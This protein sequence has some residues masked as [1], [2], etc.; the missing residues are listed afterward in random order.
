MAKFI[1]YS[2]SLLILVTLIVPDIRYRLYYKPNDRLAY[3]C[4]KELE[5][6]LDENANYSGWSTSDAKARVSGFDIDE[7]G[8]GLHKFS[9]Y[10][11]NFTLK[12]A[13]NA[14]V[15]STATCKG[16]VR[17]DKNGDVIV[18]SRRYYQITVL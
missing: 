9:V 4:V 3:S 14:D 11:T 12:N 18:P 13:F 17:F 15:K 16:S 8:E 6:Y 1:F 5:K 10:I 7:S 2:V